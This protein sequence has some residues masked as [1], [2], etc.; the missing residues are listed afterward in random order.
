MFLKSYCF[1]VLFATQ[2][3]SHT[4]QVILNQG[5]IIG[6]RAETIFDGRL[7][8]VF[9][10]VPY[11]EAPVGKLRFKDPK[12]PTKWKQP[13]DATVKYHGACAQAHIVHK[14]KIF[15]F[16]DCLHL[17]IYTPMLP[18]EPSTQ[19]LKSVLVYVHGYAFSSSLSHIYGPDFLIEKDILFITVTHRIGVFGFLK[20]D[21]TEPDV[22]M[23]LKDIVLAL[24]WIRKNI[25]KFGGD[26]NKIT[27]MGSDSGATFLSLLLMTKHRKMF[28]KMILQSGAMFSPSIFQS[29]YK[30]ERDRLKSNLRKM[31]VQDVLTA[32][33]KD[34]ITASQKIYN[35]K[36]V[37]NF[38]KPVVPFSPI[39]E[40]QS[41][42]SLLVFTPD[43]FYKNLKKRA[44]KPI[45]IGF[46]SRESISE[47]IPFLHN[48][49]YLNYF[50]SHFKFMVP[51]SDG[52]IY[53]YSSRSYNEVANRIMSHYF[54]SSISEK[55]IDGFLQYT[56]DLKKYPVWKFI[57]D[58]LKVSKADIFVYKFN[59]VGIFNAVR[60]TSLAGSKI[61]VKGASN[62][63]EICYILKCEPLIDNYGNIS[64]DANN[65]DRI[66]I[67]EMSDLWA[68]FVK[69]G[70]P[71]PSSQ[72]R[73]VWKPIT[74]SDSYLMLFGNVTKLVNT[75]TEKDTFAFWNDIYKTIYSENY[76]AKKVHDEF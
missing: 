39:V 3:S 69:T 58:H 42:T 64:Q 11:A 50:S 55:S 24:K 46:N 34:M 36:E 37:I 25:K 59:Y 26:K 54:N 19:S 60:A 2:V 10:A 35:S 28:S 68:N 1:V 21:D 44:N 74:L 63:D 45:L 65:R 15:G 23:G 27:V 51:F 61:K 38:Q 47:V 31:G 70:N 62:G 30:I 43:E 18:R 76:C 5:K 29:D 33:T 73:V 7:Y 13:F 16:E 22:N 53:N 75:K 9:Y 32:S 4:V 12:P 48:P 52:C 72:S 49:Q 8:Y 17:N 14:Q 41:N 40:K 71:T 20:V 66:F 6:T 56:T 67:E 57:N